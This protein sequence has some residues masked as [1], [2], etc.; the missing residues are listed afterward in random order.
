MTLMMPAAP[1]EKRRALTAEEIEDIV[2]AA[3]DRYQLV[4]VLFDGGCAVEE[5]SRYSG[6]PAGE[7]R[8]VLNLNRSRDASG[9]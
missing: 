9:S 6:I 8:L 5:I 3:G 1:E 7:V 4:S 2:A